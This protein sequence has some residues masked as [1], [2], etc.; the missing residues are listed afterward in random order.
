MKKIH[1]E[2]EKEYFDL[3]SAINKSYIDNGV[4]CLAVKIKDSVT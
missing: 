3:N 2:F 1:K 4:G